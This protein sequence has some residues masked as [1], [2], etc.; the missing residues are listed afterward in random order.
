MSN[1]S[2]SSIPLSC[3]QIPNTF[4]K[5][6]REISVS[7]I[8]SI[9]MI[10]SLFCIFMIQKIMKQNKN[11]SYRYLLIIFIFN[12]LY[13][14]FIFSIGF[15]RN[16]TYY[17]SILCQKIFLYYDVFIYYPFNAMVVKMSLLTVTFMG[18]DRYLFV[19]HAIK[20]RHHKN[21][22]HRFFPIIILIIGLYAFGFSIYRFLQYEIVYDPLT[23]CYVKIKTAL[24]KTY[25]VANVM[26]YINSVFLLILPII[27][28]WS[29][30]ILLFVKMLKM[31]RKVSEFKSTRSSANQSSIASDRSSTI[32]PNSR[33]TATG[34]SK[35]T[36]NLNRLNVFMSVIVTIFTVPEW[37]IMMEVE[38]FISEVYGLKAGEIGFLFIDLSETLLPIAMAISFLFID[39]NFK[40]IYHGMK[41][42]KHFLLFMS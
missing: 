15:I 4:W 34:Q 5:Q 17:T 3:F 26:G 8:A 23:L 7:M 20:Y 30:T 27:I 33:N 31:S 9:G 10:T 41:L 32:L 36:N 21:N 25:F 2:N 1:P 13:T 35:S 18:L 38:L 22:I 14:N 16:Y 37:L 42:N 29:F 39:K 11:I 6:F 12:L 40:R 19:A 24:A 28:M